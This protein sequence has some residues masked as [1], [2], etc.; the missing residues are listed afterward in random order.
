MLTNL[1]LQIIVTKRNNIVKSV[2]KF[3][4]KKL[5]INILYLIWYAE[6]KAKSLNLH[7]H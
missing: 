4:L 5:K 6:G 2:E 1:F 7:I 3:T